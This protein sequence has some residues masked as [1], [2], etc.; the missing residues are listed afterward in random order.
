[1]LG[2]ADI[3]GII[4]FVIVVF[5]DSNNTGDGCLLLEVF[6]SRRLDAALHHRVALRQSC[7]HVSDVDGGNCGV[8]VHLVGFS[9]YV[10]SGFTLILTSM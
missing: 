10:E 3:C 5:L 4:H 1:M 6:L 8:L 2:H 7:L 9:F